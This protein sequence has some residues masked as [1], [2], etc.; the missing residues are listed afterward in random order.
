M[1]SFDRIGAE[2]RVTCLCVLRVCC[3]FCVGFFFCEK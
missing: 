3:V 2:V 1:L